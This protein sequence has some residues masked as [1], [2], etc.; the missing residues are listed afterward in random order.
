[1]GSTSRLKL[2]EQVPNVGLDRLLGE[3]EPLADLPVHQSI[4]HELE[5]LDLAGGWIGP[6]FP[7]GGW[8]EGDD[9]SVPPRASARRSRLEAAAVIAIPIQDLL[10]LRGV[11]ECGI[12]VRT[13]VL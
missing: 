11:H 10:T 2:R 12:G 1:V 4:R 5:D 9:R 8:A 7:G 3:E 6:S 13:A